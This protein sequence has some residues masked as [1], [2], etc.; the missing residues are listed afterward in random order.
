MRSEHVY[1]RMAEITGRV[2]IPPSNYLSFPF[3]GQLSPTEQRMLEQ[4]AFEEYEA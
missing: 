1:Q 2:V 3:D 4:C